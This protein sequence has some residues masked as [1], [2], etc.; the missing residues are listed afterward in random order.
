MTPKNALCVSLGR[1]KVEKSAQCFAPEKKNAPV[2]EAFTGA[3]E[4]T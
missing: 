1:Q 4:R 2:Y 3:D